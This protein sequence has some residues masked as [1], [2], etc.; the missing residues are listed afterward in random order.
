MEWWSGGAWSGGVARLRARMAA[1]CRC[2]CGAVQAGCPIAIARVAIG[3]SVAKSS[4]CLLCSAPSASS[5]CPLPPRP[6]GALPPPSTPWHHA[7][8]SLLA[9]R[10]PYVPLTASV[11]FGHGE[12]RAVGWLVLLAALFGRVGGVAERSGLGLDCQH[13]VAVPIC[14]SVGF[15]LAAPRN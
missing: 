3:H 10:D 2:G 7:Y 14:V 1:T 13:W 11:L 15:G 4:P 5:A 8:L 6:T 12:V 9:A